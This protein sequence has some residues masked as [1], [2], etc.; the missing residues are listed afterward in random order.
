[1]A[2][3]KRVGLRLAARESVDLGGCV[4]TVGYTSFLTC[5]AG[6]PRQILQAVKRGYEYFLQLDGEMRREGLSYIWEWPSVY[7]RPS[8]VATA[9][10]GYESYSSLPGLDEAVRLAEAFLASE[11][12]LPELEL[13]ETFSTRRYRELRYYLLTV[14]RER[15]LFPSLREVAGV[16]VHPN[17]F[18]AMTVLFKYAV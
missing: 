1:M 13:L 5:A 3:K 12:A 15:L 18:T 2:Y 8:G 14:G 16:E 6:E 7:V 10:V 9:R 11:R 4:L 17:A